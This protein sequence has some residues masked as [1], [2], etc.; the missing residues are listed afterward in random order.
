MSDFEIIKP[1]I[2]IRPK[3]LRQYRDKQLT[4]NVETEHCIF[5]SNRVFK[6]DFEPDPV[7]RYEPDGEH[8]RE[9]SEAERIDAILK[10]VK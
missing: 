2:V 8:T 4:R 6:Q 1:E 10:G 3:A 9:K 7:R 5:L